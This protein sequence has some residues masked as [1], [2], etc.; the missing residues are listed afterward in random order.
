M[1]RTTRLIRW[2][3]VLSIAMLFALIPVVGTRVAL[4]DDQPVKITVKITDSGF[5]PDTIEVSAGQIV[6][7]TFVWAHQA[8]PNEEHIIVFEGVKAESDKI[9]KANPEATVKFVA[10]TPGTFGFKCDI[11]CDLHDSLQKGVLKVKA[12]SGTAAALQP[13]KISVEP[14]GVAVRAETVKVSALLLDKDGQPIPKAEV[15]F[16]SPRKFM[17]REGLVEVGIAKTGPTGQANLSYKPTTTEAQKIVVRFE[18]GGLYDASETTVDVP[19]SRLFGPAKAETHISLKGLRDWAPLGFITIIL[20]IWAAFA[21]MLYQAWS[22][23]R[24]RAGG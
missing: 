13:S 5:Q 14:S 12:G 10:T 15:T 6:E 8:Y 22:I 11:E 19:G 18:G 24:V 3:T 7:I 23:R 20:G 17:G 1:K 16:Y 4:A 2:L 21:F 9:T